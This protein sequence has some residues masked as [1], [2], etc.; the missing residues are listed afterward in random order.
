MLTSRV[1]GSTESS[2]VRKKGEPKLV[3]VCLKVKLHMLSKDNLKQP[4]HMK[5]E[6]LTSQ[7]IKYTAAQLIG[8]AA[9]TLL[10]LA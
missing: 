5:D 1:T 6:M 3:K 10:G 2:F 7:V 4:I 8:F 9:I